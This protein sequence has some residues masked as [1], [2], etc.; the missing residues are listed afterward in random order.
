MQFTVKLVCFY[1]LFSQTSYLNMLQNSYFK[2][3]TKYE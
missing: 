3:T 1:I 2:D